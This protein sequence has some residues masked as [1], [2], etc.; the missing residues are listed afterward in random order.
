MSEV[1]R[2][3]VV[4]APPVRLEVR[5]LRREIVPF[6]RERLLESRQLPG[7][8]GQVD[9]LLFEPRGFLALPLRGSVNLVLA[10]LQVGLPGPQALLGRAGIVGS[11]RDRRRRVGRRGLLALDLMPARLQLEPLRGELALLGRERGPDR[12]ELGCRLGAFCVE[13]LALGLFLRQRRLALGERGRPL[14]ESCTLVCHSFLGCRE[15]GPDA[16]RRRKLIGERRAHGLDLT[17]ALRRDLRL[18]QRL[19]APSLRL[20]ETIQRLLDRV[21][22]RLG[23]CGPDVELLRPRVALRSRATSD[24]SRSSSF[25]RRA[26]SAASSSAARASRRAPSCSTSAEIS[27]F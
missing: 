1:L 20:F 16:L 10:C 13:P 9:L 19:V 6:G 22:E 2:E 14:F 27:A 15:L 23:L 24:A 18:L 12:L 21:A 8:G 3:R 11:A 7:Q 26:I 4:G 17:H 5:A 25:C